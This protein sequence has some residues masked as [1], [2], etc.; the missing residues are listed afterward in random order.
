[1]GEVKGII[2]EEELKAYSGAEIML[3]DGTNNAI[4]S[5]GEQAGSGNYNWTLRWD[6]D[7][8][9]GLGWY[10]RNHDYSQESE[11][12]IRNEAFQIAYSL[13]INSRDHESAGCVEFILQ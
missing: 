5:E 7:G 4:Q 11:E 2:T 1:M 6:Q 10:A 8:F 9:T 3:L 12:T 13:W